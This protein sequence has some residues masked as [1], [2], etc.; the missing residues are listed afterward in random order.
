MKYNFMLKCCVVAVAL[1]LCFA[2]REEN[3]ARYIVLY[4]DSITAEYGAPEGSYTQ[5]VQQKFHADTVYRHGYC[6]HRYSRDVSAAHGGPSWLGTYVGEVC[7]HAD[8]DLII[9]FAGTNDYGH[10]MPL[11]EPGDTATT[12]SCGGLQYILD[13]LIEHTDA[14]VMLCTPF[15]NGAVHRLSTKPNEQ[16]HA[17]ADYVAAYKAVAAQERY[18]GRV[19][20]NDTF[21]RCG[22][23]P[24][25]EVVDSIRVYT[26]DGLHLSAAG[27]DRLTDLQYSYYKDTMAQ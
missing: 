11:G 23:S 10:G 27:Y 5:L 25:D 6:G 19:Y 17:M 13:Y 8:A 26:T 15:P 12:T 16:G 1:L 3:D 7:S 24:E 21:A 9:L 20:V 14:P 4:G 18:R 2:C 22:F